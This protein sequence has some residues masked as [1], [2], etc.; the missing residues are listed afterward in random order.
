MNGAERAAIDLRGVKR[1]PAAR[2]IV[3][4]WRRL[5]GEGKGTGQAAARATLIACSGGADSTALL[6]ALAASVPERLIVAHIVHD[7]RPA[8]EAEAD[9]DAV[10]ALAE[11]LG[12]PQVEG[13]AAVRNLGGNAEAAARRARYAELARLAGEHGARFVAT[14]HQADDQLETVL[15]ALVR[16]AGP[17]GLRG[18]APSRAWSADEGRDVAEE[19]RGG[20]GEG[21]EMVE[22]GHGE[23]GVIRPMLGVTRA[24]AEGLCALA[25]VAWREDATNLDASRLRAALRQEVTPALRRLRPRA[26]E[27]AATTARLMREAQ[28]VIDREAAGLLRAAATPPEGGEVSWE[29]RTLAEAPPLLIGEAIRAAAWRL[30]GPRGRDRLTSAALGPIVRAIRDGRTEPR[31]FEVKG[32][33]VTVTAATVAASK[34]E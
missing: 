32:M 2:R 12:L 26:S 14:G 33:I 20:G 15:M 7:L 24:D 23:G 1:D 17:R 28:E 29:R 4:A 9:R 22:G 27:R 21:A 11:R 13:R 31:H 30:H 6:L 34:R 16:G 5:T 10:R 18:I 3:A 19:G 8:A 25:G